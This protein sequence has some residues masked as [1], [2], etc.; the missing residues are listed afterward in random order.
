MAVLFTVNEKPPKIYVPIG[1]AVLLAIIVTIW[2][3]GVN[4]PL[5]ALKATVWL[6]RRQAGDS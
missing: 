1:V 5:T 4:H 3:G 2:L 6:A